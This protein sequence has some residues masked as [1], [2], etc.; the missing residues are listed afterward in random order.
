VMTPNVEPPPPRNAQKRSGLDVL[1]AVTISPVGVTTSSS[2]TFSTP[3]PYLTE[4][5]P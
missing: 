5:G 1:L 4:N 2:R 3:R